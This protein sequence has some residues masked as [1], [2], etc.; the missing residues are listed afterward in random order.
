MASASKK[1]NKRISFVRDAE[2][3]ANLHAKVLHQPVFNAPAFHGEHD[4]ATLRIQRIRQQIRDAEEFVVRSLRTTVCQG[5]LFVR[6]CQGVFFV[7]NYCLSET[8]FV[9]DY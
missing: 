2:R 5:L 3:E 7:R 9:M 4:V 1:D 8:T 6:I